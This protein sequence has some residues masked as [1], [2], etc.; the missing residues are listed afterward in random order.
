MAAA[1]YILA[2]ASPQRAELLRDLPFSFEIIPSNL[3]EPRL[4]PRGCTP[5]A[6]A[7][8]VAHFKAR[9]VAAAQPRRW[10]LGADTIVVCDGQ[11][12]GKPQ[13]E[14]DARRMLLAQAGRDT[15]VITGVSLIRATDKPLRFCRHVRCCT[16]VVRMKR[17]AAAIERYVATGDWGGKAGAY[18]IQNSVAEDALIAG[19]E[20]S[21]SNVVG[22]P[23]EQVAPLLRQVLTD[24]DVC[25]AA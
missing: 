3:D 15:Y 19:I 22:L 17:D 1:Q 11:L 25:S 2:S 10:V 21:F 9:C 14:A 12:F 8:A 23:L 20:G 5:A 24:D 4:K 7:V 18:G 13:D 16:T 6:W